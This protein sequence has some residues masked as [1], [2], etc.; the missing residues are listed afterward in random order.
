MMANELTNQDRGRT[1]T[2]HHQA[3]TPRIG[4]DHALAKFQE[5]LSS[6]SRAQAAA[7]STAASSPKAAGNTLK[8]SR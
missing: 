1:Q 2:G 5:F 6:C 4:D 7:P 8:T 3:A